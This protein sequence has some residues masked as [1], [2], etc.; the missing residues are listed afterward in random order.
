[1]ESCSEE[2]QNLKSIDLGFTNTLRSTRYI[3]KVP[4]PSMR[5]SIFL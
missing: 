5:I 2:S 1:M 4:D 3:P